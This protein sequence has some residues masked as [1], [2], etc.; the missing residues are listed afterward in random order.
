VVLSFGLAPLTVCLRDDESK[1]YYTQPLRAPPLVNRM[2]CRPLSHSTHTI[3]ELIKRFSSDGRCLLLSAR[4][5]T[6]KKDKHVLLVERL[7][8]LR[9]TITWSVSF[10]AALAKLPSDHPMRLCLRCLLH[11]LSDPMTTRAQ[12]HPRA[13]CYHHHHQVVMITSYPIRL[14]KPHVM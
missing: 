13:L 4:S 3:C 11:L 1:R 7:K 12:S 6:I 8:T 9:M 2:P 10:R 14:Y 5:K